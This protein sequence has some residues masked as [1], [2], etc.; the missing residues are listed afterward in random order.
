MKVL[1]SRLARSRLPVSGASRH[2]NLA[3]V[4]ARGQGGSAGKDYKKLPR[5]YSAQELTV[6]G[7]IKLCK[8]NSHYALQVMRLQIGST[9][10][11]FNE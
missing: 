6:G 2:A 4:L 3:P 11:I 9:L 1:F 7:R 5:L 10:R 8:D